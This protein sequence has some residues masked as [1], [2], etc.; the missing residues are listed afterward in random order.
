MKFPNTERNST[1]I[2]METI[3]KSNSLSAVL[4]DNLY[5]LILAILLL[6]LIQRRYQKY[7]QKKRMATLY[8]AI[9]SLAL[10]AVSLLIIHFN[11]SD[12]ILAPL[13]L[14]LGIIIYLARN[15][16]LPFR[17]HCRKCS[18][19][20]PFKRIIFFDSNCCDDCDPRGNDK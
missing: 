14:G 6:N 9:L 16:F 7:S 18:K 5:I 2:N 20:L 11:L 4:S 15:R 17:L 10:M 8:F 12:L 1:A 19:R 3:C 13:I